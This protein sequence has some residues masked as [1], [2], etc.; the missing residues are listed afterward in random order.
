MASALSRGWIT[1]AGLIRDCIILHL[2]PAFWQRQ[3]EHRCFTG[4]LHCSS[5][6]C[7]GLNCLWSQGTVSPKLQANNKLRMTWCINKKRGDSQ[8]PALLLLH[9][10][11]LL[12]CWLTT[13]CALASSDAFGIDCGNVTPSF[14]PKWGMLIFTG[15]RKSLK[16]WLNI[17]ARSHIRAFIHIA[18]FPL[19]Q[20]SATC[21]IL[22][23]MGQSADLE[24]QQD[25]CH[26][27]QR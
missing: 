17:S 18:T 8:K 4:T 25:P 23:K 15:G 11:K 26:S 16:H 10:P 7:Q 14:Y 24:W 20:W 22:G 6:L 2:I 13:A 12:G 21:C 19:E 9:S 27:S 3:R 1:A 5:A